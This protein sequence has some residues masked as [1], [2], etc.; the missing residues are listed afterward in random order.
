MQLKQKSPF[1]TQHFD[2]AVSGL[3][4]NGDLKLSHNS[5]YTLANDLTDLHL[6]NKN[7]YWLVS[8]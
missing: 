1:K 2:T 5:F 8:V 3:F 4:I 7:K 6:I